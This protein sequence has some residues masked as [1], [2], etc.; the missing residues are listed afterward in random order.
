[1]GERK[2]AFV[3]VL[4]ILL[5]G[6]L[7][8]N[9]SALTLIAQDLSNMV[10]QSDVII[11]GNVVD[12]QAQWVTDERG[13]HIHT[14]VRIYADSVLKGELAGDVFTLDIVGGTVGDITE[15]VSGSPVF[16]K[17]EEVILFLRGDPLQ[18]FG[19]VQG[20]FQVYDGIVYVNNKEVAAEKFL[21]ACQILIEDPSAV[22]SL[23]GKHKPG[24]MPVLGQER[25]A[26]RAP[27]S[28]TEEKSD[29]LP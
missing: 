13:K 23:D 5:V 4:T 19:G 24:L 21:E 10:Q 1:M 9:N 26:E 25:G 2:T 22:I 11:K 29:A 16:A 3:F 12:R 18:I 14:I 8:G 20:K 27:V 28:C 6:C 15:F 17:E 7:R